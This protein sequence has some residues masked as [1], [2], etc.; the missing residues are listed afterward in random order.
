MVDGRSIKIR[1]LNN[2]TNFANLWESAEKLDWE[3]QPKK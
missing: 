3:E 1:V 2:L